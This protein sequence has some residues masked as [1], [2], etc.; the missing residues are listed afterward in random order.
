ML[1]PDGAMAYPHPLFGGDHNAVAF[2]LIAFG[3]VGLLRGLGFK[4]L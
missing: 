1:H 4:F 3:I 2:L